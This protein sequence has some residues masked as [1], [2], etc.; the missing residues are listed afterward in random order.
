METENRVV[1]AREWGRQGV[2]GDEEGGVMLS[3]WVWDFLRSDESV[4]ELDGGS[5]CTMP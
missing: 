5:G 4:L 1:L 3:F 2:G